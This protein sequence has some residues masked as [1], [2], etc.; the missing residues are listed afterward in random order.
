MSRIKKWLNKRIVLYVLL[1]IIVIVWLVFGLSR[2][3][4]SSC[5]DPGLSRQY[6]SKSFIGFESQR[7]FLFFD[8]KG[9]PYRLGCDY[10]VFYQYLCGI[11][12]PIS[13]ANYVIP[14]DK[15]VAFKRGTGDKAAVYVY[16]NFR[17]RSIKGEYTDITWE[18][19]QIIL[20]NADNGEIFSYDNGVANLLCQIEPLKPGSSCCAF[21]ASERW[22]VVLTGEQRDGV[23]QIYD[24]AQ[25]E[26]RTLPLY[27]ELH[28]VKLFLN[29]EVLVIVG[30]YQEENTVTMI[31]L[32]SNETHGIDL[33]MY[34][35]EE[36]PINA[37]AV[38][39]ENQSTMYL[40]VV[41]DPLPYLSYADTKA[42]TIAVN[43]RDYTYEAI[44]NAFYASMFLK[45]GELYGIKKGIIVRIN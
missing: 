37:S 15:G 4:L 14:L 27:A 13:E 32:A 38:I 30:G 41:T 18:G 35:D 2:H 24:R 25:E 36:A 19:S 9:Q 29:N 40:S 45:N 12:I 44:D 1:G 11:P 21:L 34:Y 6:D 39:S 8:S 5:Q 17:K 10:G 33:N 16:K 28:S 22:I 3:W 26:L 20:R 7:S 31:E 23:L 42:T 43:M